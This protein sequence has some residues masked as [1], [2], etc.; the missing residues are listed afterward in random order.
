[1]PLS[2][3]PTELQEALISA[4][5]PTV[6][7]DKLSNLSITADKLSN[8]LDLA[9]KNVSLSAVASGFTKIFDQS[10]DSNHAAMTVDNVFTSTY[11]MYKIFFFERRPQASSFSHEGRFVFRTGGASGSDFT[12][13]YTARKYRDYSGHTSYEADLTNDSSLQIS[14]YNALNRGQIVEMTVYNPSKTDMSTYFDWWHVGFHP[15]NDF[16]FSNNGRGGLVNPAIAPTG[17]KFYSPTGGQGNYTYARCI[18]YG[19]KL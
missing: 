18:V 14:P 3:I 12:G 5:L 15:S 10:L 9:S 4:D 2:R 13:T 7:A 8:T 19:A 1:M 6:T 16:T 11:E 17:F